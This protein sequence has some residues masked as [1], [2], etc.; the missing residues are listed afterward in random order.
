MKMNVNTVQKLFMEDYL[1]Y[2]TFKEDTQD[3]IP[4]TIQ[5]K[6]KKL[7]TK[8]KFGWMKLNKKISSIILIIKSSLIK[9]VE[10]LKKSYTI[11]II[12]SLI[13]LASGLFIS[14]VIYDSRMDE[15]VK[16]SGYA[17]KGH[18]YDVKLRP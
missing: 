13:G 3:I 16:T 17:H 10:W 1:E 5:E 12:S 7:I 18:V 11:I 15:I 4:E 9:F 6:K 8:I 14:K 2:D